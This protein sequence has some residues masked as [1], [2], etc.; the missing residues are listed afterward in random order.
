[1]FVGTPDP[2][3]VVEVTG[4]DRDA[5][6]Q[7]NPPLVSF[8]VLEVLNGDIRPGEIIHAVWQSFSDPFYAMRGN[9]MVEWNASPLAIPR[10]GETWIVTGTRNE[11][12]PQAPPSDP[13][14]PMQPTPFGPGVSD[15][16]PMAVL[17]AQGAFV[18]SR[19][20]RVPAS[21]QAVEA[22][23]SARGSRSGT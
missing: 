11:P 10:A 22:I 1:M 7:G 12:P 6:I 23:R 15:G 8:R 17:P 14:Q 3:L 18:L 4:A 20:G 16:R 5:A 13:M 19:I 2:V 9:S 21:P